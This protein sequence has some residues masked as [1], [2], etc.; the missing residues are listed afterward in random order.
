MLARVGQVQETLM[1]SEAGMPL[2]P[3]S[4]ILVLIGVGVSVSQQTAH[5]IWIVV[6]LFAA[7]LVY[8]VACLHRARQTR[9]VPHT[10]P[11]DSEIKENA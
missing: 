4:P 1:T 3:V 2:W 8:Y 9:W 11:E 6:I 10:V 5:D 7:G